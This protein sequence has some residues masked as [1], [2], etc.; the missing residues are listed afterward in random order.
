MLNT[1][2]EL[3]HCSVAGHDGDAGRVVDVLFDDK[4]WRARYIVVDTGRWLH[5]RPVLIEPKHVEDVSPYHD[6]MLVRLSQ[7]ALEH[8]PG[9]HA[10][11]PVSMRMEQRSHDLAALAGCWIAGFSEPY[12]MGVYVAGDWP[13]AKASDHGDEHL[14]SASRVIGHHVMARDGEAGC[15][16]DF[17]VDEDAWT[18]HDIIVETGCWPHHK[19]VLVAPY[20]VRQISW[21]MGVMRV[22][23]PRE[24]V[25]TAPECVE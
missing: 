24:R 1:I 7:A 14:R 4:T 12:G 23:L 8:R 20:W 18:I 15:V 17:V 5:H 11:P 21:T 9:I 13:R 3:Q 16:A 6:T 2:Q 22:D 10:D 25:E 19:R